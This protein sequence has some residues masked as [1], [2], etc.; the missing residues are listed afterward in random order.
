[1]IDEGE[2]FGR[3][4]AFPPRLG[5]DGRWAW[6]A[7]GENIRESIQVIL[8]TEVGERLRLA[9]FGGGLSRLLFEPNTTAT[10]SLIQQR[11][12]DVLHT[13]ERRIA[14]QAVHVAPDPSDPQQVVVTVEYRLVATQTIERLALALTLGA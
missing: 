8:L 12:L 4:I 5:A 13:W 14:V 7:G 1:M 3:G 2:L 10:R 11:V 9:S 6:S